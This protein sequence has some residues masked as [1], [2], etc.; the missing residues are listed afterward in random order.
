MKSATA[1]VDFL[2]RV[3]TLG[4]IVQ[5]LLSW[6]GASKAHPIVTFLEKVYEPFLSPLRRLIKP[7]PISTSPP[8]SLDVSPLL[9]L[10]I[11]TWILHPLLLWVFH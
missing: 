1:M 4:L 8:R 7:I 6:V 2:L 11:V 3:F 10:L 9:L 5:V